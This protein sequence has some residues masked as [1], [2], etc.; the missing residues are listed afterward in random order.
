MF[1][2]RRMSEQV[3]DLLEAIEI[4]AQHGKAP[5]RRD[6]PGDL[7]LEL[8]V[9]T[10]PIG[11][12]GE[13]VVMGEEP[14]LL[15]GLLAR[16][17]VADRDGTMAVRGRSDQNRKTVIDGDNG[18]ALADNERR[19]RISSATPAR[20]S[21]MITKLASATA[22][23]SHADGSAAA[24]NSIVASDNRGRTHRGEVMPADRQGQQ[25]GAKDLRLHRVA[26]QSDWQ[27]DSADQ[28]AER[29]RRRDQNRVQ[30]I[31]P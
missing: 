20:A 4:E 26:L 6:R 17:E 13:R 3:V 12:S 7:L 31:R 5:A 22:I 25:Q 16:L 11:Q 24:E 19:S 30:T 10:R 2:A 8:L 14:D 29:N 1:F 21:A 15:L 9:E 28:T 23:A 27:R 18:I